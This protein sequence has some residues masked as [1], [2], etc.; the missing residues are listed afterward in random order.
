MLMGKYKAFPRNY[1]LEKLNTTVEVF[2]PSI[3]KETIIF[4]EGKALIPNQPPE[5]LANINSAHLYPPLPD[6]NPIHTHTK[7]LSSKE[8]WKWGGD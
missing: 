7:E 6:C 4:S 2:W 8:K 3:S 1:G 5:R